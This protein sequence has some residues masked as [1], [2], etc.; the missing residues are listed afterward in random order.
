[1]PDTFVMS[2]ATDSVFSAMMTVVMFVTAIRSLNH[3]SL[4]WCQPKLDSSIL[5]G[6]SYTKHPYALGFGA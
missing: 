6:S 1:M 3:Q 4:S 5:E 2:K